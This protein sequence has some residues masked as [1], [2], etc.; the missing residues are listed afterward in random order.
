[1]IADLDRATARNYLTYLD[2]VFLTTEVL[3]W[4]T[5]LSSRLS[6]TPKVFLSGIVLHLGQRANSFGDNPRHPRLCPLGPRSGL[7]VWRFGTG[8][9]PRACTGCGRGSRGKPGPAATPELT[10]HGTPHTLHSQFVCLGGVRV[11]YNFSA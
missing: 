3:P 6:K 2:T 11:P 8:R 4:S 1:V 10:Q 5:N 7:T 9:P